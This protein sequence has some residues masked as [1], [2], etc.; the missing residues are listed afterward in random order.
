MWA[1]RPWLKLGAMAKKTAVDYA[2]QALD[3]MGGK[4]QEAVNLLVAWC[5]AQ[6]EVREA[7]GSIDRNAVAELTKRARQVV[8]KALKEKRE[9]S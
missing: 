3:R 1:G 8:R 5:Q 4:E 9:R 6:S 7:L 2:H